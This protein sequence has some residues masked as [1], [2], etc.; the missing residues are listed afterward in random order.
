MR[1]KT[2]VLLTSAALAGL[3]GLAASGASYAG[4]DWHGKGG[5]GSYGGHHGSQHSGMHGG[6]RGGMHG[7]GHGRDMFKRF[8]Q[9]AD[10]KVT[11]EEFDAVR[12]EKFAQYDGDGNGTMAID[13]FQALW[14]EHMRPR[15]VDHFQDLDEDGD[16]QVTSAEF[17]EPMSRMFSYLDRNDDGTVAMKELKG[18]HRGGDRHH[19]Y[20]RGYDDD[21]KNEKD[22]D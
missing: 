12:A 6:M 3:I 16:G 17:N 8:D 10:G 22:D 18:R 13:E 21:D 19:K 1:H 4:G 14:L 20:G 9:N 15:M 2:K 7:A 5:Q 11:Q